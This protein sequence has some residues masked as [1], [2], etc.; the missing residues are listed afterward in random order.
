M[1]FCTWQ[2]RMDTLVRNSASCSFFPGRTTSLTLLD[3]LRSICKE[4]ASK[5][6]VQSSAV[7]GILN[8]QNKAGNTALH[9]AALN[10][11]LDPVMLLLEQGADPTITNAHGHDAIYEAELNDKN[12]IVEWIL[13][14][15]SGLQSTIGDDAGEEEDEDE[16]M[17]GEGEGSGS[18]INAEEMQKKLREEMESMNLQPGGERR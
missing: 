15:G 18:G 14:E 6:G 7:L 12:E 17:E 10:G 8:V 11:H 2:L 9:W 5:G 13:K 4:L 1:G 16:D 3:L